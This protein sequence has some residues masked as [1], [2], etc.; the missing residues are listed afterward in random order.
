MNDKPETAARPDAG[1]AA[2][3][4]EKTEEGSSPST[5]TGSIASEPSPA[6]PSLFDRVLG[7]FRQRNGTSLREEIAGALAETA[8][9]A[10]AFSPGERAMLNNILRLREV[11]VEDVMVPRADIE[12]VEITTTLGDLLGLFEQ[13]GHSRMPV[14][15]ETLDDPRGMV[16]IRDVLAHIT[17]VARVKKG[18]TSRKTPAAAL[19]DLAQVDLARTIGDL[20]LIRPVLFVPPSMLASDLM[21]RMQTTRTQMALVIDEY[22]GTDG[23]AS[24]EDIVEMVVGDIEDEHDDDE[25]M[26][27]QSGE[28]NFIVD[29]K[30]EIDEVAKM[31]GED[32]TAGEHGEYVDTIGGMIFNT[33]GRVPARGEVV[34]AIPG[35]EFHVLD[36]DPRRVKRVRIVQVQ[37]GERRRRAART[38]QA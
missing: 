35:F 37:K 7:L 29:G 21:G 5:T 22:G 14:Y 28:G 36:A 4:S 20:N 31:I 18:R 24:L 8:S 23:L 15:S 10:G 26:I 1:S 12:A 30:A 2:K 32:F 6:G 3:P 19:L 34:Q 16:H 9:D 17:K 33:L 13:S 25:P 38:E 11:R 27:T